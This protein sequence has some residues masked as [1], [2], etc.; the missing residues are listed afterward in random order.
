MFMRAIDP[1]LLQSFV[2]VVDAQSFAKAA[3]RLSK[4]QPAVSTHIRR[5]EDLLDVS[6]VVRGSGRRNISLT[7]A[8][9]ALL[10][11]A[12]RILGLQV[13]AWKSLKNIEI[14]GSVRL[15][16]TEDH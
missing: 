13:E 3:R 6:L 4:T 15:G 1:H 9:T 8:G 14:A 12:R 7:P 5:L 16:G 2:S 11:L 10:P